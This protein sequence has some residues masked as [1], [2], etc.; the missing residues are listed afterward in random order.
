[1]MTIDNDDDDNDDDGGGDDHL[2]AIKNIRMM[3]RV[4][5]LTCLSV[6]SRPSGFF[7]LAGLSHVPLV[8]N[9]IIVI[10][11]FS[12]VTVSQTKCSFSAARQ[13]P[14]MSKNSLSSRWLDNNNII[15]RKT[16]SRRN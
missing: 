2:D 14:K 15:F 13:T 11:R 4:G 9:I 7:L 12:L 10:C 5:V 1:M 16:L 6:Y 3:I 8:P